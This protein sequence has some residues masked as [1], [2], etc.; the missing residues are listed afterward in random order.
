MGTKRID[1]DDEDL[2]TLLDLVTSEFEA[3][4][5]GEV[6][7]GSRDLDE[8]EAAH[9]SDLLARLKDARGE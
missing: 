5:R 8:W 4:G 7:F 6:T 1:V 9:L 3:V 2:D